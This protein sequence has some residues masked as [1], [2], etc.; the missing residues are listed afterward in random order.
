MQVIAMQ[1]FGNP[2]VF[3]KRW[4]LQIHAHALTTLMLVTN[5]VGKSSCW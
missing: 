5:I 3:E 4:F 1:I 2:N